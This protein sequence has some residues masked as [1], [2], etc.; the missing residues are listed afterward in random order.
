M[1]NYDLYKHFTPKHELC[2]QLFGGEL[3][4]YKYISENSIYQDKNSIL[5]KKIQNT[6]LYTF[7]YNYMID[8]FD[9]WGTFFFIETPN[10]FTDLD[11]IILKY[12][13]EK[14]HGKFLI[15]DEK[16]DFMMNLYHDYNISCIESNEIL[17]RNYI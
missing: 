13:L 5:Y 12:K 16:N 8:I 11:D 9:N 1:K 17:I 15:S 7:D 14:L 3:Q 6:H 4:F 10:T 2:I